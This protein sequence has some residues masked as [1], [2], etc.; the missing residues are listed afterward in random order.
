MFCVIFVDGFRPI[1][2]GGFSA[3]PVAPPV[4]LEHAKAREDILNLQKAI[5][6]QHL[7]YLRAGYAAHGR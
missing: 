4:P 1:G 7:G 5:R 3:L 2:P 6:E